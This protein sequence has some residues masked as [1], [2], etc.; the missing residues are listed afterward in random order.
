MSINSYQI[1][2][3]VA[4]QGSFIRA[5]HLLNI[6]SSAISHSI[7]GLEKEFGYP[8]LTRNK[9]GIALTSYGE[10][11]MPYVRQVVNSDAI[12]RQTVAALNGLEKGMVRLGCFNSICMT[13]LPKLL[14]RFH[15]Q[16]PGIKIQIFQGIYDDVIGWLKNG[17]IEIGFLSMASAE[18][19]VPIRPV[20]QDELLCI[21][22]K[23]FKSASPGV[24]T[25]EEM[26]GQ[27]F[28][29]QQEAMDS[30][31]QN[32]IHRY[33]LQVKISCHAS[34]DL[35]AVCLVSNGFGICILPELVMKAMNYE[36]DR[37]ALR[38]RGFRTIGISCM[39]ENELSPAAGRLYH[40][41]IEAYQRQE[42]LE[43]FKG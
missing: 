5:S 35:S 18:N 12:L 36:V 30:D 40:F 10:T 29:A 34:D 8:L 28:I 2:V 41:M 17:I 14:N 25:H 22:P 3:T 13:H 9:S 16:Y 19:E 31:V 7:A 6:T 33:H 32:Y 24:I 37:Y 26:K 38:P 27:E 23:D 11:L 4:E 43:E 1:F 42:I 21:A 15:E 20:Y 39:E